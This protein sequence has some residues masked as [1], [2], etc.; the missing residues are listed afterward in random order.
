MWCNLST[1]LYRHREVITLKCENSQNIL[2]PVKFIRT[3]ERLQLLFTLV[4]A[5]RNGVVEVYGVC[6]SKDMVVQK[7]LITHFPRRKFKY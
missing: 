2:Q 4:R 6:S 3:M 5:F 7:I 1:Y